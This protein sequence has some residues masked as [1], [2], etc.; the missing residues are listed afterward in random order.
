MTRA[1]Y[2]SLDTRG[3]RLGGGGWDGGILRPPEA[4]I[5]SET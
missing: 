3:G 2:K 1:M 5:E 4:G